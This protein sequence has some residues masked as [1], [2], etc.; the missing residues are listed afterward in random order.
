MYNKIRERVE[1]LG[2]RSS[3][4]MAAKDAEIDRLHAEVERVRVQFY[5]MKDERDAARA[6]VERL[7][8]QSYMWRERHRASERDWRI[9]TLRAEELEA[10]VER[11]TRARYRP[12]C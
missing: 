7:T 8:E 1:I 3:R 9:V 5:L 2:P 10:E 12:F 4:I 11:L 6:E